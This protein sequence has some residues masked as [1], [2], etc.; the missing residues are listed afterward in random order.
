MTGSVGTGSR[1]E[2]G[3]QLKKRELRF[4][5]IET[6]MVLSF[7][8]TRSRQL[9]RFAPNKMRARAWPAPA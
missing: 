6:E 5:P 8:L 7:V 1:E 3:R 2:N 9:T 4:D